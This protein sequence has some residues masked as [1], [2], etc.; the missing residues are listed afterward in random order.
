MPYESAEIASLFVALLLTPVMWLGV[1]G[2]RVSGKPLF[3]AGFAMLLLSLV[4][5]IP[6]QDPAFPFHQQLNTVEHLAL[7]AAGVLFALGAHR[8]WRNARRAGEGA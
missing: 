6:D 4:S 5:S 2:I 3:V 7:G 1:R 8:V